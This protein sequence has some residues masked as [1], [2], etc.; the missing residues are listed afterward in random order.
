[1]FFHMR[2]DRADWRNIAAK[3]TSWKEFTMKTRK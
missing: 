3:A 2:Y 1:M